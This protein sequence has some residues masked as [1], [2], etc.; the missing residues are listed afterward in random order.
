MK[1]TAV[2]VGKKDRPLFTVPTCLTVSKSTI[3]GLGVFAT[4]TIKN[5]TVFG[6]YQGNFTKGSAG[7]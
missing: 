2:P 7:I 6:P 5:R 4:E 1:P 3:A